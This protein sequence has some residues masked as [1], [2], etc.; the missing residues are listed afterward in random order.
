MTAIADRLRGRRV[1]VAL[2]SGFFGFFHHAG[3]LEALVARGIAPARIA[4]NSAGALVGGMYASGLD[5][6]AIADA[7]LAVRRA[8]FWDA[9]WP[10]TA[11][12]FGLLSGERLG[13]HLSRVLPVHGFAD[14]RLPFA[15][16]VYGIEDGR[17]RHLTSGSLVTAIRAS[18]AVP[19]LF[20]PVEVGGRRCWDGGFAEKTPLAPFLEA[21]DVDAVIVSYLP[22]R[23]ADAAGRRRF[24]AFVP[25]LA[26]LFADTPADERLERDRE[27][28]RLL[29]EA[30][31]DVLVLG[32]PPSKLGP[33]SLARGAGAV[34]AG[35]EG[36]AR[37]LDSDDDARLGTEWLV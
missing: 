37:I 27:G 31:V 3:V 11:R 13:A 25:R 7:L 32:P 10:L 2:S 35:R 24:K 17:T 21:R 14:C 34:A 22:P 28:V 15:A 36:A 30:G 23:D 26:S 9:G 20:Q 18:C 1:G 33:F 5:P 12:G 6:A 29:R 16:G 8:D 4:G 19:Y